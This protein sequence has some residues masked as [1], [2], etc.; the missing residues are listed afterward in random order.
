[1]NIIPQV[2]LRL[3][4]DEFLGERL[5]LSPGMTLHADATR[6]GGAL[7]LQE[8]WHGPRHHRQNG[9]GDTRKEPR[10]ITSIVA[11]YRP[12]DARQAYAAKC[13]L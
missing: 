3:K 10:R 8:G 1:M 5:S 6:E 4:V 7:C 9:T 11:A 2:D 13:Q 12:E